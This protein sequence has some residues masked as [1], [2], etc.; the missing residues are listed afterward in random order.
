MTIEINLQKDLV[1]HWTMDSVDLDSGTVRDKSAYAHDGTIINSALPHRPGLD[2]D[3]FYFDGSGIVDNS[4]FDSLTPS[5]G[6]TV[7]A[8]AKVPTTQPRGTSVFIQNGSFN[9]LDGW[10]ITV[11]DSGSAY[12]GVGSGNSFDGQ[13]SGA[14]IPI[15]EWVHIAGVYDPSVPETRIHID[16]S[17]ESTTSV[18]EAPPDDRVNISV[19]V[20]A[21]F[22]TRYYRGNADDVR[23]YDRVLS[24]K[25]IN[26]LSNIRTDRSYSQPFEQEIP[27][28][29]NSI[30]TWYP[31]QG[32]SGDKSA[33]QPWASDSTDYSGTVNGATKLDSGGV[34]DIQL[35]PNAG[36]YQFDGSSSYIDTP[37][38]A[39]FS[40]GEAFS[41]SAWADFTSRDFNTIA[42]TYDGTTGWLV[43]SNDTD[44]YELWCDGTIISGGSVPVDTLTH[45][46][47]T[48]DSS[49][50][51]TIYENGSVVVQGD[52]TADTTS[53]ASMNIGRYPNDSS[54]FDGII[55]DVRVYDKELSSSEVDRIYDNTQ[56]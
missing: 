8:F 49:G 53:S 18:S 54:Y 7:T 17:L 13:G 23:V 50:N 43:R 44:S 51:G 32:A 6:M 46:V 22:R 48:R 36:A 4:S 38:P 25:E 31:F 26:L 19:G 30:T 16:G 3:S 29:G 21:G 28:A 20:R 14:S 10:V 1:L 24:D 34:T 52:V 39:N 5:E 9:N 11:T 56:P 55:D 42:G 27:V 47:M 41:V 37:Y 12:F 33:Y 45:I 35:G 40:Q 2:G 15:N